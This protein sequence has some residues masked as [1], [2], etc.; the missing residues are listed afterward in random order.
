MA[1]FIVITKNHHILWCQYHKVNN[2]NQLKIHLYTGAK[3]AAGY[4]MQKLQK[5]IYNLFSCNKAI[6][7]YL[8]K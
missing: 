4:L 6:F 2:Q 8:K 1:V 5:R 3:V 7:T